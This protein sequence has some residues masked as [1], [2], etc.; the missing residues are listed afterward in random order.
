MAIYNTKDGQAQ[1]SGPAE[2][3]FPDTPTGLIAV[4]D[5]SGD[6]GSVAVVAVRPAADAGRAGRSCRSP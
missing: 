6:L 3:T 4:V 1:G 5:D 2:L